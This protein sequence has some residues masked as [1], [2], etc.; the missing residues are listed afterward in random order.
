MTVQCLLQAVEGIG[1]TALREMAASQDVQGVAHAVRIVDLGEDA[2]CLQQVVD[3]LSGTIE[4]EQRRSEI[5]QGDALRERVADL[6]AQVQ[7]T[8]Q[9]VKRLLRAP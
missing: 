2:A 9:H 5:D 3:A 7:D 8:P 4:V 1:V 6:P